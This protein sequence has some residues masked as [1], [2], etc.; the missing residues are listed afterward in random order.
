[1][2][3]APV[4]LTQKAIVT[5]NMGKHLDLHTRTIAVQDP[6]PG[7]VVVR[8]V[9]SGICRSD[10]SF[11][12]GPG[13]GY[14][15]NNHIAGHEGIGNIV[16]CQDPSFVGR[17][18]RIR[19]LAETCGSCTQC[20]GPK[21]IT[22]TFQG[23]ATVPLSCLLPI[24]D[25]LSLHTDVDDIDPAYYAAALCS[26]STALTALQSASLKPGDILV[27]IGIADFHA[28]VI[29]VDLRHKIEKLSS[30]EQDQIGGIFLC[31]RAVESQGVPR[32]AE[33]VVV[34]SSGF[35][36]FHRSDE[37]V[38]DGGRIVCVGVPK[39]LNMV[40]VPLHALERNLHLLMEYIRS[41]QIKPCVTKV[42]LDDIP[43]QMQRILD[44]ETLGKVV[45]CVN[46][47]LVVG[48]SDS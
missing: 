32:A 17:S 3:G 43:Q 2:P 31:A 30:Q 16:K 47:P 24:P 20:Q 6:A 18:V 42:T 12:V 36:A 14:P 33:A 22:G 48:M 5:P 13:S 44:C 26:G 8:I 19:Y 23:Y 9:Y 10:V 15:K 21:H 27:V 34:S 28:R 37:Y 46:D 45:A 39:G 35:S 29:G 1:M 41:G 7:E 4:P 11:S 25:S 40:S 38:C